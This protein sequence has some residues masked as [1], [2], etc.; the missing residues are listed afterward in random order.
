M[1]YEVIVFLPLIGAIFAGLLNR[2]VG[3]RFP[4]IITSLIMV[5]VALLSWYVFYDV[6]F[7]SSNFSVVKYEILHWIKSD[8]VNVYWGLRIDTLTSVMFVVINSI[9]AVVHIYS[10]GY[11]HDDP[12][13]RR[14][15]AYLSFFTFAMLVL[16]SSDNLLQMFF[17]WEGVGLASYLLIGFWSFKES[18]LKASMKAFVVNR[19]GDVGLILAIATIFYL[20]GSGE[21]DIIFHKAANYFKLGNSIYSGIISHNNLV[22][23][24]MKIHPHDAISIICLFLFLGAMGK[25]AQ[26]LFHV[27]L[28]DAME[29]PT[30]VSALIHAATMVTAGIFLVARMSP[31][32]EL[33]PL[34][35]EFMLIVGAVTAFFAATVGLVQHDIKR[36]IAYSTC[37]QLGYMFVALG[38]GAY[39]ASIFH[40]FTHAF[41]K[42]LLFLG[43]GSVIHAVS[44]EQD[45]RRMGGLY[46]RL[47]VT[48]IMM[49]IG[50]LALTG[51][52]IPETNIGFSGFFSKDII[53]EAAY[54][55]SHRDF[56]FYLLLIASLF[57]SFYSWRLIFLT[58]FGQM[59]VNKN[60]LNKIHESPLVMKMPLFIL[61]IGSV[62]FGFIFRDFFFGSK[63]SFF[64]KGALFSSPQNHMLEIYHKVPLWI[65]YVPFI[66]FVVGFFASFL[67]YVVL[68]KFPKFL[69]ER[70]SYSYN[71]LQNAWYFDRIYEFCFVRPTLRLSDA[72]R[73]RMELFIDRYGPNGIVDCVRC[74]LSFLGR[75]QTG[76]IYDYALVMLVGI[77]MLVIL[78]LFKG[79]I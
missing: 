40:L 38:C 76:Y 69:A 50:S 7:S 56:A 60:I 6:G 55:S 65:E 77:S 29:G 68:P 23:F 30:P 47:P 37:S 25:S 75:F 74:A 51:F 16:V 33:S 67:M 45:M 26:F 31:L 19:I 44:G 73:N 21:F 4:E 20:F 11:M 64:W 61:S 28:P 35:L 12:H 34:V 79:S 53:L 2:F 52:G 71:F 43:A 32:F 66:V 78:M 59:R 9:S 15:F 14:F 49:I 18:A 13:R 22:L 54:M 8:L 5:I 58:F 41:F 42:A 27:W 24:G 70:Y 57:T 63:Y 36:V 72:M 39:G 10:I 17:G 48:C 46:K 1:I 62:L 3:E